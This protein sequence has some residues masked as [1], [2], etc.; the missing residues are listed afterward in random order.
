MPIAEKAQAFA[1]FSY[2]KNFENYIINRLDFKVNPTKR[3]K[4]VEFTSA[5]NGYNILIYGV[6]L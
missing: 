3:V 2:D 1:R 4:K 5:N 6:F